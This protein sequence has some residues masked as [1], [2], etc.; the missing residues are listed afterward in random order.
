[1]V[2]VLFEYTNCKEKERERERK[3]ARQKS[4]VFSLRVRA[5][6]GAVPFFYSVDRFSTKNGTILI[7]HS[8]RRRARA[9][10][11]ERERERREKRTIFFGTNKNWSP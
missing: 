10:E 8:Q 4:G 6:A 9:R 11:R 3:L 7:K 2:L 1:M 5:R